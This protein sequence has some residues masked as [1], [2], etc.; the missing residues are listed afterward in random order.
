MKQAL[1]AL[2][3]AATITVATVAVPTSASA[4]SPEGW[5]LGEAAF[6]G[7]LA[8][9]ALTIGPLA[10]PCWGNGC[11]YFGYY[12]R[13]YAYYGNQ[14]YGSGGPAYYGGPYYYGASYSCVR[15]AWNGYRW[16]R[17]NAC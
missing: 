15:K 17:Y 6:I 8:L 16:V 10:G 5:R 11:G 9:N 14:Y 3:A 1:T 2:A 4:E 12:P 13:A 7:S